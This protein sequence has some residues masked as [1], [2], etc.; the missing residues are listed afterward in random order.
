[1][2]KISFLI[3]TLF[4]LTACSDEDG[5]N[6]NFDESS[7]GN[8]NELLANVKVKKLTYPIIPETQL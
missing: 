1:M 3:F 6:Y 2:K 7:I 8:P 5:E 4:L